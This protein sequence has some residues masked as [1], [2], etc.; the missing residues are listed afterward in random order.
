MVEYMYKSFSPLRGG[1]GMKVQMYIV[2]QYWY[3]GRDK[4][5]KGPNRTIPVSKEQAEAARA[6][7]QKEEPDRQFEIEEAA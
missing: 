7:L 2:V 5:K 4:L 1:V 3:D 6:R